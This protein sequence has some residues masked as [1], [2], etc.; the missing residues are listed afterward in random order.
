MESE[1]WQQYFSCVFFFVFGK[2]CAQLGPKSSIFYVFVLTLCTIARRIRVKIG[3]CRTHTLA[4]SDVAECIVFPSLSV[5]EIY[6][7]CRH[8]IYFLLSNSVK[9]RSE[10]RRI[11][12]AP[13][14]SGSRY[15]WNWKI[16]EFASSAKRDFHLSLLQVPQYLL[17]PTS[18]Y[19]FSSPVFQRFSWKV[20]TQKTVHLLGGIFFLL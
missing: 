2:V 15:R 12:A 1:N 7:H 4:N 6:S 3:R 20:H 8:R 14:P 17:V 10:Y 19:E 13:R 16:N 9:S 18:N 5:R 11:G